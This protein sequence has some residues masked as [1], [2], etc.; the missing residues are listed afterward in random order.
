MARIL[1]NYFIIRTGDVI[2]LTYV[3]SVP[4]EGSVA[5]P[6]ALD[7]DKATCNIARAKRNFM[8]LGQSNSWQYMG[9][10]TA[11]ADDPEKD[12]RRFT[13]WM[14]DWN[15]NHNAH[16]KFL[17]IFEL[18]EKGRRLHVHVL[19]MDVPPEFVREYTAAEYA[20][21]PRDVKKLYSQ[22]KT[23]TGTRLACC[24]WW[25]FGWTTLIPCDGSP[26]VVSYMTKYMTKS[27]VEFTTKFGGHSYFASKGLFRPEKK[28][29]P[30][31][32]ARTAF[33]RVPADTWYSEYMGFNGP[34]S[35][36]FV[37]DKDKLPPDLWEYYSDLYDHPQ[38]SDTLTPCR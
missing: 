8:L 18:G 28:K 30:V 31:Y 16:I 23:E 25:K 24:P 7:G 15:H 35:L 32:A 19:L 36:C 2:R 3:K 27:S 21:L 26:K 4:A 38:A 9:T 6:R 22:Y 29:I 33:D 13:H 34:V 14:N 11:A 1:D 20:A 5:P 37:L 10:F 12:I 17:C